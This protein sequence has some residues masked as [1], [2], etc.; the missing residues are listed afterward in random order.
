ME[1]NGVAGR[2]QGFGKNASGGKRLEIGYCK[3][4][5][6]LVVLFGVTC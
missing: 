3:Y 1:M 5:G 2:Q 4:A 6:C